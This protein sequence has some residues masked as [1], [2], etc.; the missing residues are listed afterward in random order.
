MRKE[1]TV[2]SYEQLCLRWEYIEL[3]DLPANKA[4]KIL[5]CSARTLVNA[6]NTCR[7]GAYD[8]SRFKHQSRA[9]YVYN[10]CA[11]CGKHEASIRINL[12]ATDEV[13]RLAIHKDSFYLCNDCASRL[14]SVLPE[15]LFREFSKDVHKHVLHL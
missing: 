4:A 6:L 5:G 2:K 8:S 9:T 1:D 15:H 10:K 11:G 3:Q 12:S 7:P 14:A 13:A